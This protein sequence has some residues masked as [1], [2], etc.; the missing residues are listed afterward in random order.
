[1]L[2]SIYAMYTGEIR[3][4]ILQTEVLLCALEYIHQIMP[5]DENSFLWTPPVCTFL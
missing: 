3:D 1:M 4:L 5:P 2:M